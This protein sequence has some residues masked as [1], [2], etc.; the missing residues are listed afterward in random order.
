MSTVVFF[1]LYIVVT[2]FI[3]RFVA[4]STSGDKY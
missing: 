4:F 2:L 1:A 3:I